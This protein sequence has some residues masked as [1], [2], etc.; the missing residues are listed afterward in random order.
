MTLD[1]VKLR[2]LFVLPRADRHLFVESI[3]TGS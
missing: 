1:S 2:E 3:A